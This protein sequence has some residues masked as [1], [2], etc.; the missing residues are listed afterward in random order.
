LHSVL[1]LG[2]GMQIFV[3]ML[4]GKAVTLH[5]V[6]RLGGGM[7]IFVKMLTGKARASGHPAEETATGGTG[8]CM[9]TSRW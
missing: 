5:S 9:A 4:T 6:L 7:Q 3:K 1:R 2:G 8:P